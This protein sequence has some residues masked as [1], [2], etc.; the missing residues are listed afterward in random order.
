MIASRYDASASGPLGRNLS[1]HFGHSIRSKSTRLT[2]SG[3]MVNP[4]FGHV[5]FSDASTFSKLIFRDR[6][7]VDL[8][9]SYSAAHPSRQPEAA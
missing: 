3:V 2:R 7:F 8:L 4:H 6:A 1:R 5:L 9:K